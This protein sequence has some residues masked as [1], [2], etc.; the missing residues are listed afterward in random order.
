MYNSCIFFSQFVFNLG[1]GLLWYCAI[2]M[3]VNYIVLVHSVFVFILHYFVPRVRFC[4]CLA[5]PTVSYYLT[6]C[7]LQNCCNET[8]ESCRIDS[9]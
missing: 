6:L 3:T 8:A 7:A 9:G 2:F 5:S 1:R 4:V